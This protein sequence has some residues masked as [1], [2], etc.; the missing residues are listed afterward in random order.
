M[1]AG[2]SGDQGKSDKGSDAGDDS[3]FE[4]PSSGGSFLDPKEEEERNR[5]GPSDGEEEAD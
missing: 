1:T 3:A 5:W 2:D 4:T